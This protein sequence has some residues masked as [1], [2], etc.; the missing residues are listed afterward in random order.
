MTPPQQP[1]AARTE[2][3]GTSDGAGSASSVRGAD[4][5]VRTLERLGVRTIF[6]LSG[7]HV[8]PI[9]DALTGSPIR[10]I[11]VR[12]EAACVHMADAY[13]R[14]TGTL[15]VALVTGGPGHANGCAALFAA[16]ANEAPLL[17]LSGHAS[18][19]EVGLGAFQELEQAA[20]AA[21]MTK[22]AFTVRRADD[23]GNALARASRIAR[24][25]RTGPVHVSLPFDLLEAT[26]TDPQTLLP[27]AGAGE[28]DVRPFDAAMS[29]EVL[30]LV[31]GAARPLIVCGPGQG[32]GATRELLRALERHLRVPAVVMESPRGINDPALGA[33]AEILAEADL[34]VLL[35]KP[36]DFTL[37]FGRAPH[38]AT[39]ARFVVV[40]A[41][42]VSIGRIERLGA[43]RLATAIEADPRAA[44]RALASDP[45]GRWIGAVDWFERA[46][47]AVRYRPA[48]WKARADAGTGTR[49]IHP[50]E[51]CGALQRFID[52]HADTL[53]VC[54][55]GEIGQWPQAAVDTHARIINGVAGAIG[56]ALP[57]ALAACVARRYDEPQGAAPKPVIAVMG[58]GSAGF[59]IAEF[60]TA[61]RYGL[62]VIVVVGND[63]RWNAEYQIQ[64][65]DY[66]VERAA[67]CELLPTRY[68][69]VAE[70][71][72]GHGERV[73]DAGELDAALERA[74]ASGKPACLNV[75]IESCAAPVIRRPAAS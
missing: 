69:R 55:G 2:P 30:R 21:P 45:D 46:T 47:A 25:A 26:L 38:V 67:H 71:F 6:S 54:D 57:F 59:H 75:M 15:G 24:S 5:I 33:F 73:T 63:A 11:H 52:R 14:L 60:D 10:L 29:R 34:L 72:G 27:P 49:A 23:L 19:D 40:D 65:R 3:V 16:Q 12:H 18:R 39:S 62:P 37:R 31:A 68:D 35:G 13:A 32:D 43:G 74:L 17:L 42:V 1:G 56:H 22:Q 51:L 58:D 41:D 48:A 28:P 64:L 66:G 9:Y 50:L 53:L 20:V 70:A 8:M 7:N 4:L 61:V 44:M 36:L